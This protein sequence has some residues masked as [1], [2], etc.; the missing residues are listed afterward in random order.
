MIEVDL[1]QGSQA[2]LDLRLEKITSTDCAPIMGRSKYKNKR[3][4]WLDKMGRLET[5]VNAAMKKGTLLEPECRNFLEGKYGVEFPPKTYLSSTNEWQMASL[6]GYS[7]EA[8]TIVEIKVVGEN[9]F[10]RVESGLIPEQYALQCHHHM[11]CCEDA[12]QVLLAFFR[13]NEEDLMINYRIE[14]IVKY[15]EMINRL[16]HFENE[17]YRNHVITFKDPW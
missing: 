3:D 7:A 1:E 5:Y 8:K 9:T 11:A 4:V 12:E 17:F 14:T 10:R 2:W 6:D 13:F 16:T 15:P